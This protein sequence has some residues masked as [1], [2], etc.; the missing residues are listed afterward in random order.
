MYRDIPHQVRDRISRLMGVPWQN[1]EHLQLLQYVAGQY[2]TEH[3][4]QIA[5]R[6]SSWGPRLYTFFMYLSDVDKGGETNFTRLNLTVG[7]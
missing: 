4:D 1:S 6:H 7:K 2:Y 3:H 5:P